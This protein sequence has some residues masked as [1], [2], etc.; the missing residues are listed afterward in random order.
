MFFLSF[1]NY[2]PGPNLLNCGQFQKSNEEYFVSL[3]D[4]ANTELALIETTRC[5]MLSQGV[6][7]HWRS[8]II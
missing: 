4:K 2:V 3:F 6:P 7:M 1:I 8:S 5:H